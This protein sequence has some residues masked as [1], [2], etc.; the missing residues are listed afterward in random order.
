MLDVLLV[1]IQPMDMQHYNR[2]KDFGYFNEK[3]PEF[4]ISVLNG[5]ILRFKASK[6]DYIG[7][8]ISSEYNTPFDE[9][10]AAINNELD[11]D[12]GG[13]VVAIDKYPYSQFEGGVKIPEEQGS[14]HYRYQRRFSRYEIEC[15]SENFDY[16]SVILLVSGIE[17]TVL[18]TLKIA[19]SHI[20]GFCSSFISFEKETVLS[21]KSPFGEVIG[22]ALKHHSETALKPDSPI[23]S[24]TMRFERISL[25]GIILQKLLENK[26]QLESDTE[27]E[28]NE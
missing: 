15:Q 23:L 16:D 14:N 22:I 7:P 5:D 24:Y 26:T 1:K 28:T 17:P 11:V 18:S 21:L 4:E 25:P 2:P 10:I 3:T 20:Q 9:K 8:N 27:E 19:C 13:T 12:H 6:V